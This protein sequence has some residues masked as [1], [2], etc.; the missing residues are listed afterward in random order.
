MA[1][2]PQIT[3][4]VSASAAFAGTV[5]NFWVISRMVSSRWTFFFPPILFASLTRG[6]KSIFEKP[7]ASVWVFLNAHS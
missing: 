3:T 4:A 2:L 5:R 1:D 7:P 6:F